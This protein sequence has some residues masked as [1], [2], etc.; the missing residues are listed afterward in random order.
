MRAWQL[1]VLGLDPGELELELEP[2][3]ADRVTQYP[4]YIYSVLQYEVHL[5]FLLINLRIPS[6]LFVAGKHTFPTRLCLL[7]RYSCL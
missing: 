3:S 1:L 2:S 6:F 7:Y 4:M 5:L